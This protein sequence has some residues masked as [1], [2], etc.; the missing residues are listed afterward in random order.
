MGVVLV[1]CQVR[2]G[3]W[4]LEKT[5]RFISGTGYSRGVKPQYLSERTLREDRGSGKSDQGE[6][7]MVFR[8]EGGKAPCPRRNPPTRSGGSST[9]SLRRG[10]YDRGREETASRIEKRE[11]AE[12]SEANSDSLRRGD[13]N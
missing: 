7:L 9:T 5:V 11:T 4:G 6:N 10:V 3:G 8:G 12:S 13:H 1:G 2:M